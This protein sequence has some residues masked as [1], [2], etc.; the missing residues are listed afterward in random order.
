MNADH[1]RA[2]LFA[3]EKG[4]DD[5]VNRPKHNHGKKAVR[6]Q[7]ILCRNK[8]GEIGNIGREIPDRRRLFQGRVGIESTE[9]K[10]SEQTDRKEV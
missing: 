1:S 7:E 6:V 9:R 4:W 3:R 5:V 2:K 10:K 8:P